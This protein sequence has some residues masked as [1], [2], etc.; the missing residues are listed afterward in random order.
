MFF[1]GVLDWLQDNKPIP[2]AHTLSKFDV[3]LDSYSGL[4]VIRGRVKKTEEHQQ[5]SQI[6]M[7]LKS[8]VTKLLVST[9]HQTYHHPGSTMLSLLANDYYIPKLRNHLKQL[10]RNC[11]TCQRAYAQPTSQKMGALP[12]AR[13]TPAPPFDRVE[14]DFAGLIKSSVYLVLRTPFEVHCKGILHMVKRI[15]CHSN[16]SRNCL[17][18]KRSNKIKSTLFKNFLC[19]FLVVV[20]THSAFT[21]LNIPTQDLPSWLV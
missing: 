7:S 17:N 21:Q 5:R 4:I 12:P 20:V 8:N 10:S 19:I 1:P 13:T 16:R 18:W 3:E 14:V 6:V 11:V 15:Q 9:R 2:R